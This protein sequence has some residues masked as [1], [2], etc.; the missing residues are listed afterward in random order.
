MR[1]VTFK[2]QKELANYMINKFQTSIL[3]RYELNDKGDIYDIWDDIIEANIYTSKAITL[4][5]H[6]IFL[7]EE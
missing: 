5:S 1:V 2:S 3:D 6:F 7:V 4:F